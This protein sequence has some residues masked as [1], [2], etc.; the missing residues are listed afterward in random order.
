MSEL[1]AS[2]VL[3]L[4]DRVTRPVKRI[5]QQFSGLARSRGLQQLR[6]NV[7]NVGRQWSGVTDQA[8]RLARR[9]TIMGGAAA[10]AVWGFERLVGGITETA[11]QTIK[12]ADRLG[13]PIQRLQ[14]WR[15]GAE[16]SGIA[17]S[18]FDM[19]LQRFTRRTAEAARGT[20]E[21]EGALKFLDIQLQDM[22]GNMRPTTELLPEVAD[23]LARIEDPAVRVRA[24]FKLFD[25]EGVAML[26]FLGDGS[27]G[28]R[29]LAKEA[30]NAG[31]VM[32]E[33]FA[34]QAEEYNDTMMDFRKTLLGVR[35]AVV[36]DMLPALSQWIERIKAVTQGNREMIAERV[37]RGLRNFWEGVKQVSSVLGRA[38]QALGG[39]G[40]LAL[41]VGAI[42]AGPLILVV[43]K[44]FGGVAMLTK[45]LVLFSVSVLPAVITGVK[46][47]GVALMTTP[48]GW[49]TAA[50]AA[51]A[52]A[53]YLIYKNWGPITEFVGELW[54]GVTGKISSAVGW[55]K[56]TLSP[57]ALASIGKNWIEGLRSGIVERFDALVG[58]LQTRVASLVDWMPDWAQERFGFDG[59]S[60]PSSSMRLGP[61]MLGPEGVEGVLRT[62]QNTRVGGRLH[63]TV[64]SEGRPRV[65][66]LRKDGP[67]DLDVDAGFGFGGM[68]P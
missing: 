10:G 36:Q 50:I 58:W 62:T 53:A 57:G 40:N 21:A 7:A 33:A 31:V 43:V 28:M 22:N 47:L 15:Y 41:V 30:R 32:D 61:S 55:I 46:A 54:E 34:R 20:G 18:T 14:E 2:I 24:A 12:T 37:I 64:D 35:M 19:A 29:S 48:V 9:L 8:G 65:S 25:S 38:S 51:I 1:K 67:M 11:D 49:V 63:I 3:D 68:I 17:T 52:G 4:V 60:A 23:A 45:S 16:R 59:P 66:D 56:D 42:L 5:E 44:L 13:V 39:W 27:D 26:N 6:Q